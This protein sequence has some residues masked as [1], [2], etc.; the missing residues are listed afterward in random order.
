METGASEREGKS[1]SNGK[2]WRYVHLV[3]ASELEGSK[4]FLLGCASGTGESLVGWGGRGVGVTMQG[5]GFA[6][7]VSGGYAVVGVGHCAD[8][9]IA[10]GSDRKGWLMESQGVSDG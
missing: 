5:E 6:A 2:H 1:A 8:D 9:G 3:Q 4:D 7:R 10:G